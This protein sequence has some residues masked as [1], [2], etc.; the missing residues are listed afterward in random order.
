MTWKINSLRVITMQSQT[1]VAPVCICMYICHIYDDFR[2]LTARKFIFAMSGSFSEST[3]YM[4]VALA[5][6]KQRV[7]G[8]FDF[9]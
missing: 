9:E 6:A 1:L 7:H 4:K 5:I 3:K 8:W 2:N